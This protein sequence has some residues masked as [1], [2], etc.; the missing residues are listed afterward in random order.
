MIYSGPPFQG[1]AEGWGGNSPFAPSPEFLSPPE[2]FS[3]VVFYLINVCKYF[4]LQTEN[5]LNFLKLCFVVLLPPPQGGGGQK[6]S[7]AAR[8]IFWPPAPAPFQTVSY[9]QPLGKTNWQFLFIFYLHFCTP[10]RILYTRGGFCHIQ[11]NSEL[12]F[13]KYYYILLKF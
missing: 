7:C 1:R 10:C 11:Y 6:K 8:A 2:G 9:F 4:H 5:N 13:K 12:L 3:T